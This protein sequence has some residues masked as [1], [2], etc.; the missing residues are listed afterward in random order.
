[1][2]FLHTH[3]VLIICHISC[4]FG[5]SASLSSPDLA[6]SAY[7]YPDYDSRIP[8]YAQKNFDYMGEYHLHPP[9]FF[10][11]NLWST[12]RGLKLITLLV[13]TILQY[14]LEKKIYIFDDWW[15]SFSNPYTFTTMQ[16][17]NMLWMKQLTLRT[18]CMLS[19]VSY[20]LCIITACLR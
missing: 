16:H 3:Y 9:F 1:M 7:E 19:A 14:E 18:I 5:F 6:S 15:T 12:K 4:R 10:H 2:V 11:Y 8:L 13:V 17:L 20:T